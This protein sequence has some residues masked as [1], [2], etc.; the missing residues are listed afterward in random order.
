MRGAHEVGTGLHSFLYKALHWRNV[1]YAD[2]ATC[3]NMLISWQ[4]WRAP[5]HCTC[6]LQPW[7]WF[8]AYI[9]PTPAPT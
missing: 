4:V 3:L 8:R 2:A 7:V 9:P 6:M 5:R 1:L